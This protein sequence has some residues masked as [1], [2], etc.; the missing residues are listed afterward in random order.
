MS[1]TPGRKYQCTICKAFKE[2]ID[3]ECNCGGSKKKKAAPQIDKTL[4]ERGERY[5]DFSVQAMTSQA[6]KHV[7]QGEPGWARLSGAQREALELIAVKISRILNGDPD[8]HDSWYDIS[9]YAK[10]VADTLEKSRQ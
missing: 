4:A 3:G 6:L 5:G 7:I 9:G 10:L 2:T 8:Y 1:N